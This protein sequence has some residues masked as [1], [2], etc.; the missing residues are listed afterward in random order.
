LDYL[1]P[2]RKPCNNHPHITFS[3]LP[4]PPLLHVC[5][6]S[7]EVA[8]QHYT[9][10][11]HNGEGGRM[12]V[13]GT[14]DRDVETF[15]TCSHEVGSQE[16]EGEGLFWER[17]RDVWFLNEAEGPSILNDAKTACIWGGQTGI[18]FGRV[19]T[20]C[21]RIETL[22][23]LGLGAG[24]MWESVECLWVLDE[25]FADNDWRQF[26]LQKGNKVTRIVKNSGLRNAVGGEVDVEFLR[27]KTVGG[28]EEEW[29]LGM[30][31]VWIDGEEV[32]GNMRLL[33]KR[34]DS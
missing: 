29:E 3:R 27:P 31:E 14:E 25:D 4:I 28:E 13:L 22:N 18:K 11:F 7:R 8:L 19:G 33:R 2:S 24:I 9:A 10:G 26:A 5:Q 32:L 6:L 12:L 21:M 17:G 16:N 34:I 23:S 20:L 1:R 30:Q 15:T